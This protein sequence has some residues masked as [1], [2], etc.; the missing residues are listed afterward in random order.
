MA[1]RSYNKKVAKQTAKAIRRAPKWVVV[2]AIILVIAIAGGYFVYDRY[3]KKKQD[4]V[5]ELSFHFLMLGNGS[6]GDSIYIRAGENDILIDAGSTKS[7]AQTII[8]Y[9]DEYVED[10][11]LEYVIV[12]HEDQDHI[13]GF[14]GLSNKE[15]VFDHYKVDTIIEFP[16]YAGGTQILEDYFTARNEEVSAGAT[17]YTALQCYNNENGA[18]RVYNLAES[19]NM[20]IL[21]NYYYDHAHGDQNN[22][23]VCVQ[24]TH[25]EEKFLFTGDLE[26]AGESKLIEYNSLSKVQL[27]KAGHHGSATSSNTV[28]LDVID[29][30]ICVVSCAIGDKHDFPRQEFINRIFAYTLNVYVTTMANDKYTNGADFTAM[31]GNIVVTSSAENGIT[32]SCSNNSTLLKDTLWFSEN[33]VMPTV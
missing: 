14:V 30:E 17:C 9:V 26:E 2:L 7:S 23:S 15:S 33:R 3:F 29:P 12:T 19:V 4:A 32:V 13:A 8:E 11:K 1:K 25:G 21:Y 31:N 10:N 16:K 28:L 27:F 24:F 18:K 22:Y 20:E 6:S 5:G